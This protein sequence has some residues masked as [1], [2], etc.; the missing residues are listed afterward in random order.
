M[1]DASNIA[2]NI[3]FLS[4]KKDKNSNLFLF[5]PLHINAQF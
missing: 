5:P 1:A 4:T 2:T 3:V